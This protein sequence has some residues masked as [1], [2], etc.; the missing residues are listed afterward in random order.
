MEKYIELIKS[1]LVNKEVKRSI[2]RTIIKE[3]LLPLKEIK[4]L[5]KFVDF[6]KKI[7]SYG[8]YNIENFKN[9]RLIERNDIITNVN[10]K[11]LLPIMYRNFLN[12]SEEFLVIDN[13]KI[14]SDKTK[15]IDIYNHYNNDVFNCDFESKL[16]YE[17]N[18]VIDSM[19]NIA[20]SDL[21]R[22]VKVSKYREYE[23]IK[24]IFEDLLVKNRI[25]VDKLLKEELS[26]FDNETRLSLMK[27]EIVNTGLKSKRENGDTINKNAMI[28]KLYEEMNNVVDYVNIN[29]L[30]STTYNGFFNDFNLL[31]VLFNIKYKNYKDISVS[32]NMSST[33]N[34]EYE[35]VKRFDNIN[36][37]EIFSDE[38]NGVY[39]EIK[40]FRNDLYVLEQK[41]KE[42]SFPKGIVNTIYTFDIDSLAGVINQVQPD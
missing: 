38:I 12:K 11:I 15:H 16:I 18:F 26:A 32:L 4:E 23:Q 24:N 9:Q 1:S 21:D 25:E 36:S 19:V 29:D 31:L 8:Y 13:Y 34:D 5:L 35:A 7:P 27:Y 42:N 40:T 14:I 2:V 22:K 17:F 37:P 10:D 28:A 6:D 39:Y 3:K 30:Y 33:D 41:E 20:N